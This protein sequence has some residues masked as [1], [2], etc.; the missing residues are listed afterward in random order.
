MSLLK[1]CSIDDSLKLCYRIGIFEWS[2][3]MKN[4]LLL[5]VLLIFLSCSKDGIVYEIDINKVSLIIWCIYIST[6]PLYLVIKSRQF[7]R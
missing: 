1:V 5:S 4:Q 2:I 3:K 7:K 6:A